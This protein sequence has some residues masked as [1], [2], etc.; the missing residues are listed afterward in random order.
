MTKIG[1]NYYLRKCV[2]LFTY[3]EYKKKFEKYLNNSVWQQFYEVVVDL[4]VWH[5]NPLGKNTFNIF[6]SKIKKNIHETNSQ[7][8][9]T[10]STQEVFCPENVGFFSS[11]PRK[12]CQ[13]KFDYHGWTTFILVRLALRIFTQPRTLVTF[14]FLFS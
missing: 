3:N 7:W 12:K 9:S 14:Y 11:F 10:V 8:N 13:T 1:R 6:L 5:P 2:L 4:F